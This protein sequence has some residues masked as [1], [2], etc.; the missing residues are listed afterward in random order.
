MKDLS[1]NKKKKLVFQKILYVSKI[2]KYKVEL[3]SYS[4]FVKD[5]IGSVDPEFVRKSECGDAKED[6]ILEWVPAGLNTGTL[7]SAKASSSRIYN[8]L[9]G[10]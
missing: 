5:I 4:K 8:R 1:N 9:P 6:E 2:R 3:K 7:N 10:A